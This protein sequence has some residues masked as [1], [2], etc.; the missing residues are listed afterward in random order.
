MLRCADLACTASVEAREGRLE[1]DASSAFTFASRPVASDYLGDE[2][3]I[4][5]RGREREERRWRH[6]WSKLKQRKRN[7]IKMNGPGSSYAWA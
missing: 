7:K 3:V 6:Q 4:G 2:A 1:G 5:Q